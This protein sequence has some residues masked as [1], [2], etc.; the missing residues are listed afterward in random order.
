MVTLLLRPATGFVQTPQAPEIMLHA[1]SKI[2]LEGTVRRENMISALG[3]VSL[4]WPRKV[5]SLFGSTPQRAVSDALLTT[6]RALRQSGFPAELRSAK[7]SWQI[8]FMDEE[9]PETQV[10]SY[11]VDNCHPAWM[12]PPANIYVVA[13]RVVA[14]C[15]GAAPLK[16]RDA[17]ARLVRILLHEIGHALEARLL[18]RQMGQNRMLTEGF[19]SWFE[20]YA[21]DYSAL[22][23]DG[24][25][26]SSYQRIAKLHYQRFPGSFKFAGGAADYARASQYFW[27]VVD[28]KGVYSLMQVYD[29][30]R[31][32]QSDFFT[33]IDKKLY[34]NEEKLNSEVSRILK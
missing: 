31:S 9:V 4:R 20:Q 29:F 15:D 14:G 3:D 5:E 1:P 10:P 7:I 11:L 27:A 24:S 18:G 32:Q 34:W 16:T 25:V 13:Q 12:T 26:R 22:L 2:E 28:R 23:R 21:A 17:D 30:M 6:S 33:A 8:V 19:A